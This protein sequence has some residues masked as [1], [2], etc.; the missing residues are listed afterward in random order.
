[1]FYSES[2]L[3]KTGPLA[4]VWLAA[5]LERKLTKQNVLQSDID[6][7]VRDIIG[8]G[9]APMALRLSGQ[10]LLGVVRIYSKKAKYLFDDCSEALGKLKMAFRP[11]NVDLPA[12][13]LLASN[14]NALTLPDQITEQDLFAPLPDPADLFRD[15]GLNLNDDHNFLD[16]ETSQLMPE[17]QRTP[18]SSRRS[19]PMAGLE[20]D[21]LDLDLGFDEPSIE[22]GRANKSALP[23]GPSLLQ[24]DL[25]L[26]FG[27]GDTTVEQDNTI[28]GA[29]DDVPMHD[30]E[31]VE[32]NNGPPQSGAPLQERDDS[33]Q[34]NGTAL[35]EVDETAVQA[36]Q[37]VKRR[38]VLH[39]DVEIELDKKQIQKQQE[40]RSA[41]TRAPSYLPQDP[42]LLHLLEAQRSGA[43]VSNIMGDG[44][45]VGLAPQLHGIC[46]IEVIRKIGERKRKRDSG[47]ADMDTSEEQIQSSPQLNNVGDEDFINIG[48]QDGFG[49]D[50]SLEHGTLAIMDEDE[51]DRIAAQDI[52]GPSTVGP[53]FDHT[54]APLL[55][56]SQSGPVSVGTKTTVA[57]LRNHFAPGHT[58]NEPPTPSKRTRAEARF[59]DLCPT[60]TTKRSE[61][62]K[63]FFEL[64][65][66]GTKDAVKIEQEKGKGLDGDIRVRGKRGL[67]GSWAEMGQSQVVTTL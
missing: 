7:N 49:G 15:P 43:F 54:E 55:H 22:L 30:D 51:I 13:Q 41:I 47:I 48:D 33:F 27:F 19:R 67:W 61:A 64:L 2:L 37:R 1:M 16:F 45:M 28:R 50:T 3:A 39:Q 24:D 63:M 58:G 40:D 23:D 56:P 46:S 14:A 8:S 34:L 26:D 6:N 17:A 42:F 35:D 20:Q 11:G 66:L 32:S 44:R 9:Q 38:K 60:E 21:D 36:A 59:A 12:N 52:D 31:P 4:R 62:T 5:N 25:G 57:A 53:S 29:Q 65:V 10:L 18:T